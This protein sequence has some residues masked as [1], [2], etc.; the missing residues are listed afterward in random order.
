M[1]IFIPHSNVEHNKS[2]GQAINKIKQ[3]YI[4]PAL[5]KRQLADFASVGIEIFKNGTSKIYFDDEVH[6]L[7]ELKNK[8]ISP[9]DVGKSINIALHDI[10]DLR[11]NDKT[12]NKHSAKILIVRFSKDWWIYYADFRKIKGLEEKFKIIQTFTIRGGGHLPLKMRREQRC[13]FMKN[14]RSVL[15]NELPQM[16]RRH[17]TVS[18]KYTGVMAYDGNYFDL[19]LHAQELYV[20]GFYYSSIVICR[21][22]AEQALITILTN[23]GRGLEI[24]KREAAKRKL[25]S[26]EH[27]VET[28]RSYELF[29]KKYPINKVAARKINQISKIASQLV[30]PKNNLEELEKYKKDAIKCMDNLQY[31]IKKHLNFI[32]DTGVVSGYRLAGPSQRLK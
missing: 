8:R 5:A 22:A 17:V 12:L 14:Y 2:F 3:V 30:H 19:F 25:K 6:F 1:A 23:K 20:L 28:C 24:Y 32:K 29:K 18:Q 26:I 13:D 31:I 16:W 11:W 10:K 15:E 21:T 9:T 27:L 4:D 7:I